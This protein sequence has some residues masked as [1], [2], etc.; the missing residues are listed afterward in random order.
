MLHRRFLLRRIRQ[1]ALPPFYY[2]SNANTGK[3]ELT[4]TQP[5]VYLDILL[6]VN[7]F[8]NYFLLLTTA[9]FLGI[10][11]RKTRLLLGA[12]AGAFCSLVILLPS[13]PFLLNLAL[14]IPM[15]AV[16]VLAAYRFVSRRSFLRE[17]A[18][19]YAVSFSFAGIMLA[20]S[21]CFQPSGLLIKNAA[22]YV[23]VSP[24]LLLAVTVLCYF[25]LTIL[26]RITG[27]HTLQNTFCTV[28]V[29]HGGKKAAFLAKIDT[30]N[31]LTEPFSGLPVA[32]AEEKILSAV[33]PPLTEWTERCGGNLRMV[34]YHTVSGEGILPAFQPEK[35]TIRCGKTVIETTAFYLGIS[36][37]KLSNAYHG[38]LNPAILS[39]GTEPEAAASHWEGKR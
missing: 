21:Y 10:P 32:I 26:Y 20:V 31:G 23:A 12:L 8:I 4:I 33:I 27:R 2:N 36:S 1:K 37:R 28:T 17:L 13:M 38:L 6:S 22:V 14:K 3:G 9:K 15:S 29:W 7:L 16:M 18:C 39:T 19:L 11:Y 5:V 30:G 25:A 34:P 24:V 35:C